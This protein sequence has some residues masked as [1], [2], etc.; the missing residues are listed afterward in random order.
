[1]LVL[2][3]YDNI[4]PMDRRAGLA[5]L[6]ERI[7]DRILGNQ[8][9]PRLDFRLYGGWYDFSQLTRR[10]QDLAR[11]IAADFPRSYRRVGSSGTTH[12][13][14]VEAAYS[15]LCDPGHHLLATYRERGCPSGIKTHPQAG[16]ACATP[17]TCGLRHLP[18]LFSQSRCPQ[19]SCNVALE[20]LLYRGEQKLVDAMLG[21][22]LLHASANLPGPVA[23]VTSD[24]DLWPPIR[25]AVSMGRTVLHV[26]TDTHGTPARYRTASIPSSLHK[27]FFL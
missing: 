21:T 23:L 5:P 3:D 25:Q 19:P 12:I 18:D 24:Q 26:H 14:N 16:L 22:D 17:G 6:M 10:G 9:A 2:V 15:L 4:R 20:Q 1:M 8:S 27:E 7:A 11:E 13:L